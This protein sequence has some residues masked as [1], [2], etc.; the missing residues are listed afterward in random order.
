M[1]LA[2][3]KLKSNSGRINLVFSIFNSTTGG[4]AALE[5][6]TITSHHYF[7]PSLLTHLAPSHYTAY[8][9]SQ[10]APALRTAALAKRGKAA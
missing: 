5:S 7:L 4:L 9:S 3:L 8:R 2:G 1:H 6:V 10:F